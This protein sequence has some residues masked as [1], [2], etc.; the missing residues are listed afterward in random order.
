MLTIVLSGPG[1][2]RPQARTAL[3]AHGFHVQDT[4]HNHGL[5]A[6][7]GEA[8]QFITLEGDDIDIAHRC[9]EPLGWRLRSHWHT[10]PPREPTREDSLE[11]ELVEMRERL[12]ALETKVG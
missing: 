1:A 12:A 10:P 3:A 11:R 7:E 9:V 4:H 8:H 2:T 5:D 6:P